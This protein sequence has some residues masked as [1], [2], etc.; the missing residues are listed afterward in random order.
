MAF[1]DELIINCKAGR[2]GD[3]VVRWRQEKYIDRGGPW[4]GDGG[5][6]GDVYVRGVR[7]VTLLSK[8]KANPNFEGEMGEPG[9]GGRKHGKDGED[10]VLDLPVGS[11]VTDKNTGYSF[12][13][14]E[15]GQKVL[16]LRGGQGGL[17]NDH[18]KSSLNTTPTTATK[19]KNGDKGAFSVVVELIAE[20]GFVGLPNAG[21]SSLLNVLTNATAKIGAYAFTTLEPNLGSFHG[22]I[23]ADIPGLIEGASEGKGLGIKFLRHIKKTKILIHLVSLESADPVTDYNNIRNEL[24]GYGEGLFEKE[25]II[26]LTKT[27]MVDSGVVEEISKKFE[28]F[29][30][31]I[32]SISLF[33]DVSIKKFS[34]DFIKILRSK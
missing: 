27:D 2:G 22:Y 34:D 6:G 3:G 7:D 12:L 20:V 14:E 31:P 28:Q 16:I 4:G 18:F 23:L 21:K 1:V 17:G 15:E 9:A 10:F 33:D 29:G 19:G 13:L 25:E 5:K 30:K 24:K 8:Y 11:K 26:L 32:F